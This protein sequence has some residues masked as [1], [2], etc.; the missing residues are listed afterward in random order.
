MP[1][2]ST[3]I[4]LADIFDVSSDAMLGLKP[5][6][7]ELSIPLIFDYGFPEII[8]PEKVDDTSMCIPV[9][10]S[11][12]M[13]I[14]GYIKS[15]HHEPV[16]V[17]G[18]YAIIA[19]NDDCEPLVIKGDVVYVKPFV[20]KYTEEQNINNLL[21]AVSLTESDDVGT[22]VR[23]CVLE[24]N[25]TLCLTSQYHKKAY[26]RILQNNGNMIIKGIVTGIWRPY[27]SAAITL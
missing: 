15:Y 18:Y 16:Y 1:N 13:K 5:L 3:F 22:S 2:L 12:S 7:G 17:R 19:D 20:S 26:T 6:D 23:Q 27:K 21:C 4:K 14:A 10:I 9:Y 24:D 8:T 25:I 11:D